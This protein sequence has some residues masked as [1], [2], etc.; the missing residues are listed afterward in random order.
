[1][2]PQLLVFTHSA[3]NVLLWPFF[4]PSNP[5]HPLVQVPELNAAASRKLPWTPE[6]CSIAPIMSLHVRKTLIQ[7]MS[8]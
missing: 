3:W 1:M 6:H 4:T 5:M 2:C 8:S 7:V